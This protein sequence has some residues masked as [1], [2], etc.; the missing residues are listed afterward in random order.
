VSDGFHNTLL[1]TQVAAAV[2]MIDTVEHS[3]MAREPRSGRNIRQEAILQ[4]PKATYERL[5]RESAA[6]YKPLQQWIV[7]ILRLM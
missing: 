3:F 2:D 6:V 1:H 4:L 7:D 5:R